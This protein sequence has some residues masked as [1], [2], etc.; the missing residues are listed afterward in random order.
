M[1]LDEIQNLFLIILYNYIKVTKMKLGKHAVK[2][3]VIFAFLFVVGI[4]L[5][6]LNLHE[7]F[8]TIG[9]GNN[10]TNIIASDYRNNANDLVGE[11]MQFL[12]NVGGAMN[13]KGIENRNNIRTEAIKEANN[14]GLTI[15]SNKE[16]ALRRQYLRRSMPS[17]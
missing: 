8:V 5:K 13:N 12:R 3:L 4:A 11:R 17:L 16:N 9:S 14:A 15:N 2:V 10:A 7:G 1:V 6:F